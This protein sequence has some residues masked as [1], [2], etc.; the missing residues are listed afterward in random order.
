MIQCK[1]ENIIIQCQIVIKP[2]WKILEQ[3]Y[4]GILGNLL[5]NAIESCC[6]VPV[7]KRKINIHSQVKANYWSIYMSNSKIA[8]ENPLGEQ[9]VNGENL[10]RQQRQQKRQMLKTTK[11]N[12]Q[13]H[14]LGTQIIAELVEKHNGMIQYEDCGE[15]FITNLMIEIHES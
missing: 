13:Q 4:V 10:T 14:G 6:K 3:D 2:E 11:K 5:D 12:S 1:K 7:G 15:A 9:P 8:A